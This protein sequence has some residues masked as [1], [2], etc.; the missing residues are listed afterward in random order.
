VSYEWFFNS[1]IIPNEVTSQITV[2]KSGAYIVR[3]TD[4]NGCKGVSLVYNHNLV[5]TE[6]EYFDQ[7]LKIYPNP[8]TNLLN[9]ESKVDKILAL[10]LHD[11]TGKKIN[12]KIDNYQQQGYILDMNQLAVGVYLLEIKTI[13]GAIWKKIIKE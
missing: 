3:V 13:K 8:T 4:T 12:V 7:N 9:V 1:N 10:Q 11:I 2:T 5:S 6:D